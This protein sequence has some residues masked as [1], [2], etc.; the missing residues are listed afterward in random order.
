MK[1]KPPKNKTTNKKSQDRE[2]RAAKASSAGATAMGH[3]A[4]ASTTAQIISPPPPHTHVTSAISPQESIQEEPEPEVIGA[5]LPLMQRLR[6][7]KAKEDRQTRD[8]QSK[9]NHGRNTEGSLDRAGVV[10]GSWGRVSLEMSWT[11]VKRWNRGQDH[12]ASLNLGDREMSVFRFHLISSQCQLSPNSYSLCMKPLHMECS[13]RNGFYHCLNSFLSNCT[14]GKRLRHVDLRTLQT[15]SFNF[16]S[17][18][19][20]NKYRDSIFHCRSADSEQESNSRLCSL[21]C[22]DL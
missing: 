16:G 1:F 6:M 15:S 10:G 20:R 19:K 18:S 9:V 17:S 12:F 4:S 2:E 3:V 7:L 8:A 14:D 13:T 5:G 11:M 22:F 21:R